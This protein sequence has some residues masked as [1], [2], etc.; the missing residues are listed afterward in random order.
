MFK[1]RIGVLFILL[2][3]TLGEAVA[4]RFD[5]V[6]LE[7][8]NNKVIARAYSASVRMWGFDTLRHAQN[9]AQFSGV[10]VSGDGYILTVAHA[11]VPGNTYKVFF[12]DGKETIAVA[13]GRIGFKDKDNMP[14]MG[15]MK[16][17]KSGTWPFAEVG[18]S[19]SLKV[20]APCLSISYPE[21]LNQKLPTVR[22]G[23]VVEVLNQ[24]GFIQSSCIME[25][26]DS[27]GPLFD[28][29]GRVVG[30]HSRC[31]VAEIANLEVP[32]DLYRK[33]WDALH[34]K[35]D[36]DS[37]PG[38]ESSLPKDPLANGIKP[39]A[40]LANLQFALKVEASRFSPYVVKI[41]S[42]L[43]G[44]D[45]SVMGT[46]LSAKGMSLTASDNA[47][48][49][50]VSKSSMVGA[51]P[52]IALTP[53]R[54][55]NAS[56]LF[57]DQRTDLVF[58]QV[59]DVRRHSI[60]L[61][62]LSQSDTVVFGDLGRFLISPVDSGQFRVGIVGSGYFN[63]PRKFSSG[64]FGASANFIKERIILTRI[65][66]GS[67]AAATLQLGDDITGINGVPISRPEHYGGELMKYSD[68]DT[69]SIQL[70]RS[71]KALDLPVALTSRP[72][73]PNEHAAERFA[74]GKSLVLDGFE[75]VISQDAIIQP[76]ECGG[77]VFDGKGKFY[78]INI[79]R[80]SRTTTLIVP[81]DVI[82]NVLERFISS[83]TK[84]EKHK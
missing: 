70:L 27:G 28:E 62:K 52:T 65:A 7:K 61:N 68:G 3:S 48:L 6:A 14:D 56:V 54:Q 57:R 77:P 36:Y 38:K 34:E 23:H 19:S 41:A 16:I 42:V 47:N 64:Y 59:K 84:T 79:A 4:Q 33:Y 60:D 39:V 55:T 17:V 25:P 24:W 26:G 9:S 66:E 18:W 73:L 53:G 51:N 29:L 2:V 13:L 78:G 75:R 22:F 69:I 30:L 35:K 20:N 44:K 72:R 5:R 45:Q 46:F 49:I 37:L 10:V 40:G 43:K 82:H 1:L 81:A 8:N 32:V 63:Q 71:G 58:L 74:G 11:I 12:P 76:W 31:D 21:T 83:R 67:P 50:I 80:F 15:M